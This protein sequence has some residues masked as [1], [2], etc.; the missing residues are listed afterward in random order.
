MKVDTLIN[1]GW[2]VTVD[3]HKNVL[4]QHSLAITD[5]RITAILP[6]E[7]AK[8]FDAS[9]VIDLPQQVL[10][11][12]LI[13]AHGHSAMTLFRGMA[14]DLPL[15]TW[16]QEHIWPAEGQWVN[17]AFVADGTELAI[18]EMLKTGTTCFS[19]MYFFPEVAANVASNAHIRAQFCGPVLDFP[20]TW[21]QNANEYIDKC[22]TLHASFEQHS[23]V[24]TGFGPHA[25][26]TVSDEPLVKIGELS[27][28][29]NCKVQIHLHETAFE[30]TD[31][32]EK[33]GKRPTQ[34]LHDLGLLNSNLQVVHL[35]QANDVDIKLLSENKVSV[36]HCPE[37]NL[38][39][40]SGMCPVEKLRLANIN[41][42]L[43]TDGAASN[44]DLNMFGEM[45]TA[46]MLGKA[47][48]GDAA[49]MPAHYIL[50]MATING[51]KALGL[52]KEVGSLEVGKA[53]DII[54]V[55]F[56]AVEC[57]PI[58][59]PVSHLVYVTGADKVKNVWVNG[60]QQVNQ[61]KLCHID[62]QALITKIQA[63]S[64]KIRTAEV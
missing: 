24:T 8:L 37:S 33:T 21:A 28:T 52:D 9:E 51:A 3:T 47:V 42:C 38:K 29:M 54:S 6:W 48:A 35:T 56:S 2:I 20:T 39:L 13:N 10:M 46:A 18:A 11:P 43:G 36:V 53:A 7:E 57:Q 25:P 27:K 32:V 41:V 23:L 45:R 55:D 1:A 62:E 34:R 60:R 19:D 22:Q 30:V 49:A 63:W 16:L 59:D 14:D 40:A 17:E 50:E 5:G 61:G 4:S 58:Y 26:Y 44:N 12:G 64:H 31:A 15:M